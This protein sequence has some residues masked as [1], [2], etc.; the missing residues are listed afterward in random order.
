MLSRLFFFVLFLP[1][2][3][4]SESSYTVIEDLAKEPILTPSFRHQK[5]LKIRLAN[6][7]EALLISDPMIDQSGAVLTVKTGSFEDGEET[8]GIAHF[9]EH[10]LFLGTKKYPQESGY[11][12][13]IAENGGLTNAFTSNDFTAYIFSVNNN[14]FLEALDR[15]SEFFKEPLFNPSGV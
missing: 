3:I 4:F 5:T 1:A 12:H 8:P 11:Q 9:L 14:A 2:L 13:F 7:L 10:M 15:F 6:G